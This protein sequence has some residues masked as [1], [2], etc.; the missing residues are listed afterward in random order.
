MQVHNIVAKKFNYVQKWYNSNWLKDVS[1]SQKFIVNNDQCL[2]FEDPERVKR[3]LM[4][5]FWK[6]NTLIIYSELGTCFKSESYL[7]GLYL[8]TITKYFFFFFSPVF[9]PNLML[10]CNVHNRASKKRRLFFQFSDFTEVFWSEDKHA[11]CVV[12]S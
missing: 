2:I 6:K 9:E 4:S 12:T 5:S 7:K 10:W 3:N 1:K 8:F 11:K